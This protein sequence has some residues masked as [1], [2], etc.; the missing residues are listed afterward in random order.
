[1]VRVHSGL[2]LQIPASFSTCDF[3]PVF[4]F[5]IVPAATP[6]RARTCGCP[7]FSFRRGAGCLCWWLGLVAAFSPEAVFTFL[8]YL[9]SLLLQFE[10]AGA[11]SIGHPDVSP[12]KGDLDGECPH[13]ESFEDG[14]IAS[15]QLGHCVAAA[16]GHPDVRS[17]RNHAN[18]ELSHVERR[19]AFGSLR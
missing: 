10:H 1:M 2:P 5:F 13:G 16:V 11:A 17:V 15:S 19:R 3:L 14:T 18:R 8:H 6:M 4:S 7:R 12:V 9:Y